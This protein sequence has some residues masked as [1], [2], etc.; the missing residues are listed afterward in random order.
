MKRHADE[1]TLDHIVDLRKENERLRED[2]LDALAA[3]ESENAFYQ[4]EIKR[5]RKEKDAYKSVLLDIK[6]QYSEEDDI[7]DY[8][9]YRACAALEK[10]E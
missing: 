7:T 4:M 3:V 10:G 8:W 9:F 2:K 5:L 1:V 6:H